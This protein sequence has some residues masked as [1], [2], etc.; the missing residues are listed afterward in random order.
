MDAVRRLSL[1]LV[2]LGSA[3]C[4]CRPARSQN[5]ETLKRQV[6]EEAPRAWE[7]L[8][9][10]AENLSGVL[11]MTTYPAEGEKSVG[12]FTSKSRGRC[13]LFIEEE[14]SSPAK[15]RPGAPERLRVNV[16]GINDHYYFRLRAA[17]RD[18]PFKL[19]KLEK[20]PKDSATSETPMELVRRMWNTDN[21]RLA[22][23]IEAL[24]EIF[25]KPYFK[26]L[27]VEELQED[28]GAYIRCQIAYD[29]PTDEKPFPFEVP[30]S[31][32]S[33]LFQ[34]DLDPR[35]DYGIRRVTTEHHW[36]KQKKTYV[37]TDEFR[38]TK[39]GEAGV[40]VSE[41]TS[42]DK[43]T[44]Q[45]ESSI[46]YQFLE[47]SYSAPPKS[48]FYLSAFGLPEPPGVHNPGIPLFVWIGIAGILLVT[49]AF[50]VQRRW[51]KAA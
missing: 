20:M 37:L 12:K 17:T 40:Y 5:S 8:R 9:K 15:P 47:W 51:R 50:L 19:V 38:E 2:L 11:L 32:T 4:Y 21:F 41:R 26:L 14:I 29:Q 48:D 16:Y 23:Q 7:K 49:G 35:N 24:P 28:D 31:Y 36:P 13:K 25:K 10:R 45:V 34:V 43:A 30:L 6:L 33:T 44:N 39:P 22:I 27:S 1:I 46:K 42:V 3:C 18:G